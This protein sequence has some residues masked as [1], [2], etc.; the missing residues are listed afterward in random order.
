MYT[1]VDREQGSPKEIKE[2]V[3]PEEHVEQTLSQSDVLNERLDSERSETSSNPRTPLSPTNQHEYLWEREDDL[4]TS[5]VTAS[6]GFRRLEH[7]PFGL[8]LHHKRHASEGSYKK[9]I[10]ENS[11]KPLSIPQSSSTGQLRVSPTSVTI[12]VN[13]VPQ[14][15]S[16]THFPHSEIFPHEAQTKTHW[17]PSVDTQVISVDSNS[18]SHGALRFRAGS[19]TSSSSS[20]SSLDERSS[21][22]NDSTFSESKTDVTQIRDI[23]EL[24]CDSSQA[25]GLKISPQTAQAIAKVRT[26]YSNSGPYHVPSHHDMEKILSTEESYV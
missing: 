23:K 10:T 20:V 22:G 14:N 1:D 7:S 3:E 6:S 13:S 18:N 26:P 12:T 24:L 4:N 17:I 9:Q 8:N 16:L 25:N 21:I 5:L 2:L 11:R 15:S 19:A